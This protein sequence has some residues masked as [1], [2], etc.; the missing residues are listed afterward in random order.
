MRNTHPLSHERRV[1]SVKPDR[2]YYISGVGGGEYL[3]SMDWVIGNGDT[4]RCARLNGRFT[5]LVCV[6]L[7]VEAC[8]ATC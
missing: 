2:S 3:T 4:F 5:I 7:S 6:C 8:M 1:I